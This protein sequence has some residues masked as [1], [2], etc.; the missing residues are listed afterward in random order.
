MQEQP[1]QVFVLIFLI[2]IILVYFILI[3]LDYLKYVFSLT[4]QIIFK[5]EF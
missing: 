5:V 1:V 4:F 2:A 3:L